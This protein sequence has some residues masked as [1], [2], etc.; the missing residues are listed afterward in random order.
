M[1][2]CVDR[3]PCWALTVIG[4]SALDVGLMVCGECGCPDVAQGVEAEG[5]SDYCA[6][7]DG[8]MDV[9]T[10][11]KFV[12]EDRT[13]PDTGAPRTEA[14]DDVFA[15]NPVERYRRTVRRYW[16]VVTTA[17]LAG[18]AAGYCLAVL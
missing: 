4:A 8:L 5:E 18:V 11:R 2:A 12:D 10:L 6:H 15:D 3:G 13:F 16:I 7:C 14:I 9:V 1:C 17:F